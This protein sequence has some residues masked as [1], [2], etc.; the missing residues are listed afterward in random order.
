LG[1]AGRLLGVLLASVLLFC[2]GGCTV[3]GFG[4]TDAV[5]AAPPP[6]LL[7]M[8]PVW[9][10]APVGHS[11]EWAVVQ[12]GYSTPALGPPPTVYGSRLHVPPGESAAAKVLALTEQQTAAK[13]ENERLTERVRP[14]ETE[15]DSANQSL[16]R[17]TTEVVET[18]T[19]LTG[20]RSD[21][22]QWRREIAVMRERLE[23]ADKDNLSTLQTT[24]TLLQQL[25]AKEEGHEG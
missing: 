5:Q 23:A 12:S 24:V 6:P 13:A 15:L 1:H 14:L 18:R 22:E 11:P 4:Q 8:S 17:A 2:S 10:G 21:L 25:L 9:G 20:A 3:C 19:E 7:P 16:A